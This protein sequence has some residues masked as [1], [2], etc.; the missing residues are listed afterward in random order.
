MLLRKNRSIISQPLTE[1]RI[2][3]RKMGILEIP[4]ST[5]IAI[6][7]QE[8]DWG[9]PADPAD[10]IIVATAIAERATLVTADAEILNWQGE[11]KRHDA[12]S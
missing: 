10:R 4:V 5:E 1:F 11:L 3:M 6:L 9:F 2:A 7:S 8:L 12:R